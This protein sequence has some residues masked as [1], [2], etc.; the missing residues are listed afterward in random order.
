MSQA[1]CLAAPL[2]A[3]APAAGRASARNALPAQRDV[4]G[5]AAALDR[6]A[7]PWRRRAAIRELDR[8]SDRELRDIGID[9]GEIDA[10]VDELMRVRV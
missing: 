5:F 1:T 9:R 10:V 7:C 2:Q 4:T 3:C 6:L 8:L